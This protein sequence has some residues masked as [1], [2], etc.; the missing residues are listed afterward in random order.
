MSAVLRLEAALTSPPPPPGAGGE[1]LLDA[2]RDARD[3]AVDAY[4]AWRVASRYGCDEAFAVYLAA[5]DREAAAA[6]ALAR[7]VAH[8]RR[9]VSAAPPFLPS[10]PSDPLTKETP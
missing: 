2:W 6:D 8:G 5:D 9:R 1:A 7:W 3:E 10:S 4:R